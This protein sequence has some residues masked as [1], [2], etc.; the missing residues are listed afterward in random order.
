MIKRWD[1]LPPLFYFLLSSPFFNQPSLPPFLIYFS[2]S[3]RH[4]VRL[5]CVERQDQNGKQTAEQNVATCTD[6]HG[7]NTLSPP[8]YHTTA[9]SIHIC[10]P[11]SLHTQTDTNALC[12]CAHTV[13]S[14]YA[15]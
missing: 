5:L 10:T 4:V 12:M 7:V 11:T 1:V 2:P 9:H 14:L 15:F 3:Y 6:T 13:H 8:T